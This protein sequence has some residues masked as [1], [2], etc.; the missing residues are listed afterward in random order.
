M[1]IGQIIAALLPFLIKIV[2]MF[3]DKY[4]ADQEAKED[5]LKF[6]NKLE[7]KHGVSVR[8]HKSYQEQRERLKNG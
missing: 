1:G 4:V 2:G 6:V 8:L 7:D 5:Y 3:L